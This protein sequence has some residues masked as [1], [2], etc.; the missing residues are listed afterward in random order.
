MDIE[1]VIQNL[2]EAKK[3]AKCPPGFKYSKKQKSC[4]PVKKKG[5]YKTI[6]SYMG[7]VII[8]VVII[9][10]VETVMVM[11]TEMAMVTVVMVMA[12]VEMAVATVVAT[13]AV[14]M[15]EVEENEILL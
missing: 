6:R 8:V 15:E 14:V 10:Q 7:V 4:V 2:R 1:R 9:V 11:E 5:K 13:V 12:M 3:K